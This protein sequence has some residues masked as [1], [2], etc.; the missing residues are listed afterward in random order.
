MA[1]AYLAEIK[2]AVPPNAPVLLCGFSLG[3]IV[4]YEILQQ[5]ASDRTLTGRLRA[6]LLDTR[7][8][9]PQSTDADIARI[10]VFYMFQMAGRPISEAMPIIQGLPADETWVTYL[11]D[12][13]VAAG[14]LPDTMATGAIEMFHRLFKHHV[15]LATAYQ[16]LR[17]RFDGSLLY[18]SASDTDLVSL[19]S[20]V[21][22]VG[23][24]RL[25]IQKSASPHSGLLKP[26]AVEEIATWM[27]EIA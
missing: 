17:P 18:V 14:V 3:G 25:N 20:W 9:P 5:A 24:T 16:P 7:M 15:G 26:G 1:A 19:Q 4:A 22:L 11:Q 8:R 27:L 6:G 13:L 2:A 12:Q 10:F 21:D 23:P